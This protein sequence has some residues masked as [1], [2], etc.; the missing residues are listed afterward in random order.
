MTTNFLPPTSTTNSDWLKG[1]SFVGGL[2]LQVSEPM[3]VKVASKPEYGAQVTDFLVKNG[4]LKVGETCH[5][6][7][8]DAAGEIKT[9]DTKSAPFFIGLQKVEEL[10]IGDWVEITRTGKGTASRYSAEKVDAPEISPAKPSTV[11]TLE[12]NMDAPPF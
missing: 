4:T 10:G 8:K 11:G 12:E 9:F 1:E 3:T 6:T 2:I 5:F 7:F